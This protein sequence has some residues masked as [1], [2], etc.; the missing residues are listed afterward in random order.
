MACPYLRRCCVVLTMLFGFCGPVSAEPTL[1]ALIV[2]G[3]N[4][5]G[6]WPKT[7]K[8]MK[9]YLEQT[10]L[11]TVD[12]ATTAPKGSDPSFKPDFAK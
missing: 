1:R 6:I 5:H 7:T 9:K 3:Q 11:F 4:N 12:V 10:G 2:D 8:M